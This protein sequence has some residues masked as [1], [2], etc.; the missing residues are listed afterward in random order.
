MGK[1]LDLTGQRFGRLVVLDFSH[2]DK[3][4]LTYWKCQCDCGRTTTVPIRNLRSG[5]TKSCGNGYHRRKDITGQEFG[6]LIVLEHSHQTTRRKTMWKCQCSCGKITLV[7][8]H[9][10]RKGRVKSCGCLRDDVARQKALKPKGVAAFNRVYESAKGGALNRTLPWEITK[11]TFRAVVSQDC[12]YCG[13]KPAMRKWRRKQNGG[14]VG[15]GIDR[16]DNNKGYV[17]GNI[18]PC[19]AK[20]NRM[21]LDHPQKEFL[22]QVERIHKHQHN[23]K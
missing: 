12:Y 6:R 5:N 11:E 3:D 2:K 15:H 20:C 8:G 21:K 16:V 1:R 7:E 17:E 19:C 4:G 13:I 10:L 14:F 9:T 18:V 23:S 22:A